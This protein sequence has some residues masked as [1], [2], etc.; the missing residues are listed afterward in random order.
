MQSNIQVPIIPFHTPH[1][2]ATGDGQGR[3]PPGGVEIK[4]ECQMYK[5]RDDEYMI[6]IQR[7]SGDL[8]LYL[9]LVGRVMTEMRV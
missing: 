4:F 6:D 8:F 5:V 3:Q 2:H 7:L 1:P 9:E